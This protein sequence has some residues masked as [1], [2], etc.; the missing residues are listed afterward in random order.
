V[1][2]S[3]REKMLAGELY[4]ASDPELAQMELRAQTL[5]SRYNTTLRTEVELR[6]ALLRDL[7]GAV[8]E[9]ANIRPPFYCD[10]GVHIRAGRNLFMNFDCVLLDCAEITIGDD[11]QIGPAVQIYTAT[12]PLDP[13]VRRSGLEA[14]KTVHIGDNVWIGGAAV[15]LPG[16]TI[17]DNAVIGAGSVVTRDVP[18]DTVVVGNPARAVKAR[19]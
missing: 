11:V 18:V 10:Y 3:E 5:L 9:G 4:R 16:V 12:H 8:D 13:A 19:E 14:A 1:S 2:R 7:F 6:A 17:G 15:I